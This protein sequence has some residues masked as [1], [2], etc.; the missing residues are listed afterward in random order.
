MIPVRRTVMMD[1]ISVQNIL[2]SY[3]DEKDLEICYSKE[4]GTFAITT[5]LNRFCLMRGI[6]KDKNSWIVTFYNQ[7]K[8]NP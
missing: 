3:K 7:T 1:N 6:Q 5:N 8:E 4:A 2:E